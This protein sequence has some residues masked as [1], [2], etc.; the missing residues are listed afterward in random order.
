MTVDI[1]QVV[2]SDLCSEDSGICDFSFCQT[3]WE[4]L[5]SQLSAHLQ[6]FFWLLARILTIVD[7]K[8]RTLT[9]RDKR[10]SYLFVLQQNNVKVCL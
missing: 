10:E 2:M 6:P 5:W 1:Y 7:K 4:K 8:Y 9:G 3:E